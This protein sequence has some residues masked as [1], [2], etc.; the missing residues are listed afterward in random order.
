[1]NNKVKKS[2]TYIV[3]FSRNPSYNDYFNKILHVRRNDVYTPVQKIIL[4]N[5]S[6]NIKYDFGAF[7]KKQL[8][9]IIPL[10]ILVDITYIYCVGK[11]NK[12]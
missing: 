10:L 3:I 9:L 11:H 7:E 2:N 5:I 8:K 6:V 12:S 4:K 1:V